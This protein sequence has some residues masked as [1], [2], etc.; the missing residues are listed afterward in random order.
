MCWAD[1][2]LMGQEGEGRWMIVFGKEPA[3]QTSCKS[4]SALCHAFI[5][6]MCLSPSICPRYRGSDKEQE[7]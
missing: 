4:V 1:L 5:L 2:E 3:F 7:H 6:P